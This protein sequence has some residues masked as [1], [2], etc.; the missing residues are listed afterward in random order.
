VLDAE[1]RSRFELL[2]A[3]FLQKHPRAAR[4]LATLRKKY[5]DE[6][7]DGAIARELGVPV[8][9]VYVLRSRAIRKLRAE[10]EW[11]ALAAEF[12]IA[13]ADAEAPQVQDQG[14]SLTLGE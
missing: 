8:S 9:S 6:M 5:I 13:V 14:R 10:P 4:Q 7:D 3:A 12:E 1:R 11:R 2:A